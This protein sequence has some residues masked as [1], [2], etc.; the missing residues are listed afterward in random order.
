MKPVNLKDVIK[1]MVHVPLD[2]KE[3]Y[4]NKKTGEV[5]YRDTLEDLYSEMIDETNKMVVINKKHFFPSTVLSAVDPVA[6]NNGFF[7]W[8]DQE[9]WEQL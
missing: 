3:K 9:G 5:C 7:D 2:Y 6:Y 1:S 8:L 4:Q